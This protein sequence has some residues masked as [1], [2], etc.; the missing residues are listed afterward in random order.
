[1]KCT[2]NFRVDIGLKGKIDFKKGL[3]LDLPRSGRI[4]CYRLVSHV[5]YMR[6]ATNM[7]G[8]RERIDHLT[9][10]TKLPGLRMEARLPVTL[11]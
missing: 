10:V 3:I 11:L 2:E 7:Q 6:V 8:Q 4:T 9:V 5:I 1:M